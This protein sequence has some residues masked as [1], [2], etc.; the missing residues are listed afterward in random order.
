MNKIFSN[1][2]WTETKIKELGEF[3][4]GFTFKK[5]YQG[6]KNYEI[7]FFKI[8]DMN[9]N[10][11]YLIKS[12]N[13]INNDMLIKMG[14]KPM[15]KSSIIFAKIGEAIYLERKRI[16]NG[17]YLIDNNLLSFQANKGINLEFLYY[18]FLSIHFSKYAQQ[19][20]VP[21]LSI[22]DIGSIICKIPKDIEEQNKIVQ[23]FLNLDQKM[24]KIDRHIQ[25]L[26]EYKKSLL[27][28]MFI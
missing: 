1:V 16:V 25:L 11:K 2:T 4:S 3:K 6:H 26:K 17:C 15:N 27:Q 24:D 28:K 12:N 13:T 19:T 7:P 18:L 9:N 20:A 21:S 10:K 22:K 14:Y 23:L 5:E 8:S